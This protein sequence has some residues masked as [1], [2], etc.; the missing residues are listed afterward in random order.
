AV[1][2]GILRRLAAFDRLDR[3]ALDVLRRVEIRLACSQPDHVAAG[4]FERTRLI[5]HRDGGGRLDALER[6]GEQGHENLRLPSWGASFLIGAAADGKPQSRSTHQCDGAGT[7]RPPAAPVK[8]RRLGLSL[9]F[10][11]LSGGFPTGRRLDYAPPRTTG[12]GRTP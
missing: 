3:G 8:L 11:A 5:R 2:R 7:P 12:P 4:G 6:F 10:A 1:D 9:Q